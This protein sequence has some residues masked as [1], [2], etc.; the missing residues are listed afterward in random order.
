MAAVATAGGG[1]SGR[2]LKGGDGFLVVGQVVERLPHVARRIKACPAYQHVGPAVAHLEL[3]KLL[4][5]VL[6]IT[7][8]VGYGGPARGQARKL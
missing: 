6:G 8:T 5:L 1:E 2:V 3:E 4:H 7:V